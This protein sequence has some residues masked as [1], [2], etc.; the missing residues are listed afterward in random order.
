MPQ[1]F[2]NWQSMGIDAAPQTASSPSGI[3]GTEF[4][5]WSNLT[6]PS[7]LIKQSIGMQKPSGFNNSASAVPPPQQSVP[8]TFDEAMNKA[9]APATNKLNNIT[10]RFDQAAQGN[11]FNAVT[12]QKPTA[13]PTT[14]GEQHDHEW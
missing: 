8:M 2:Q 1:N 3:P 6:G 5:D 10:N 4:Q 11:I 13:Q 14:V 7:D 12:G 9:I